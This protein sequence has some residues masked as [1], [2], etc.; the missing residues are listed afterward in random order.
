MGHIK[1]FCKEEVYCKY[2][3]I[4]TH[5]MT[6]CR[7]YPV[8]SSRKNTPE[9]QASDDIEWEVSRRVQKEMLRILNDLSTNRQVAGNQ[10]ASQPKQD[11]RQQELPNKRNMKQIP[12]RYIPEQRQDV[13]NLIGDFQSP[14]EVFDQ[15]QKISDHTEQTEENRDPILNQHW[16]EPLNMQHPMVPAN[17]MTLQQNPHGRAQ[18]QVQGNTVSSTNATSWQV[19]SSDHKMSRENDEPKISEP[20]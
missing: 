4:Y 20:S 6:V 8:T 5:S 1:R 7:T 16:D 19:K 18:I 9:K 10:K 14:P 2:C 11:P 3:R 12:H 15:N 17:T 13:Q